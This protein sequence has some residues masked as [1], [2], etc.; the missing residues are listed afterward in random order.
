M[1]WSSLPALEKEKG[2]TK[3]YF[4]NFMGDSENAQRPLYPVATELDSIKQG[5]PIVTKSSLAEW[6]L[7]SE[8]LGLRN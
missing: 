3:S 8:S 7:Q 6:L 1:L 5:R 2:K 4:H